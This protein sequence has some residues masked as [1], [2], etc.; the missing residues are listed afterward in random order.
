MCRA[1]IKDWKVDDPIPERPE[2]QSIRKQT[3]M[4]MK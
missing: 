4:K 2:L 3:H 1:K